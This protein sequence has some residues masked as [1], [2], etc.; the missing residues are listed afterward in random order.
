MCTNLLT[1]LPVWCRMLYINYNTIQLKFQNVIRTKIRSAQRSSVIGNITNSWY[2]VLLL[3]LGSVAYF[4]L[5]APPPG[6][7]FPWR[8]VSCLRIMKMHS[9]S[10]LGLICFTMAGLEAPR[11]RFLEGV[12]YKFLNEWMNELETIKRPKEV[13]SQLRVTNMKGYSFI[14]R[15]TSNCKW[16]TTT[17]QN[18]LSSGC[19]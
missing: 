10:Y 17:Y 16:A 7:G 2:L 13:S 3:Q 15:R 14:Y 8:S 9:A 4:P 1:G 12:P 18:I 5:L 11:S 19:S 6:M